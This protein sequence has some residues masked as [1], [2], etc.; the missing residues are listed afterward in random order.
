MARL[1]QRRRRALKSGFFMRSLP[2]ARRCPRSAS[3][4]SND[5]DYAFGEHIVRESAYATLTDAD[6]KL[7]TSW[8]RFDKRATG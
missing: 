4:F 5:E 1:G 6:Q 3:K 7:A 8:A 2:D